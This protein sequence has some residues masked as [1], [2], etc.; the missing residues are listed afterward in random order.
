MPPADLSGLGHKNTS[1]GVNTLTAGVSKPVDAYCYI[2]LASTGHMDLCQWCRKVSDRR[3]WL[4]KFY[5]DWQKINISA[6]CFIVRT[7][8]FLKSVKMTGMSKK[9]STSLLCG[10]VPVSNWNRPK[11]TLFH[12]ILCTIPPVIRPC[13]GNY[14][15]GPIAFFIS[16]DWRTCVTWIDWH[17]CS[18]GMDHPLR[19][20]LSVEVGHLVCECEVLQQDRPSRPNRQGGCLGPHRGPSPSGEHICFLQS[21]IQN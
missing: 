12:T 4:T 2:L 19:N 9:I 21:Q 7:E 14:S 16:Q 5:S 17:T 10:C 11:N 8:K 13:A 20:P 15:T 6:A 3:I 18:F 1:R